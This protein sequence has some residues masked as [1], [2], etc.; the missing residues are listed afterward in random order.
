[1][2]NLFQSETAGASAEFIALRDEPR[3]EQMKKL[4]QEMWEVFSPWADP[5]FPQQFSQNVHPRFW[6]MYL[7]VRLLERNFALVPKKSSFGPDFHISLDGKSI[8]IEATAPEDGTGRDAVPSIDE[9]DGTKP[10][11]EDKII[12][13]FANAI[14]EKFRKREEYVKKGL[15]DSSDAFVIALNGR[16]INMT[17][18]EGPLPAIV[19]SVYPA[20]DYSITIDVNTLKSVREGYQTRR[21]ISKV[22]GS[23]VLTNTFLNKE[24]AGVSGILYSNA[25]LWDMPTMPGCEFLFIDNLMANIHLKP[26]WLGTGKYCYKEENHLTIVVL[27]KCA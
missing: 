25:A 4:A 23:T 22:S 7:G 3:N 14:S 20:G 27:P 21:E 17:L 11:P 6:E 18:F 26:E 5:N 16:G 24:Y 15:I 8:W 12:L 13:R 2:N 19:K 1:M 10:V 9:L